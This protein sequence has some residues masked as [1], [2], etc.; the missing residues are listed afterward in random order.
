M[1][2]DAE[3]EEIIQ[4]V[5]PMTMTSR[6]R[7]EALVKAVEYIVENEIAGDFV[8]C[9]VWKG[10][11]L[12]AMMVVL[13][14]LN[15]HSRHIWGFDTFAGMTPPA[16]LDVS[17]HGEKA[18]EIYSDHANKGEKWLAISRTTV[19]KNLYRSGYSMEKVHLVEGDV[20]MTL[21]QNLPSSV[22]LL[23]LDTDW[24]DS[25]ML[26]LQTL[27]PILIPRGIMIIDD[28]GHWGGAKKAVDEYFSK[29]EF[30]PLLQRVDYTGRL[31][32]KCA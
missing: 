10:G 11:S 31:V 7:V 2:S 24:Y 9:G 4:Q 20:Q 14:R 19:A 32:V 5:E 28:Y 8:E 26:E 16:D 22:A 23:R 1:F 18:K 13:Q 27:Y 12:F 30:R 3:V 17:I 21:K 15:D 6:E 29:T 25:T